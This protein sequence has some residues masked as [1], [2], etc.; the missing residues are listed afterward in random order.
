MA[1]EK[2][3]LV[4]SEFLDNWYV[5]E[6]AEHEGIERADQ[7]GPNSYT[8]FCSSRIS[9]ADVEGH[10]DQMV[11]LADAIESSGSV[12]FKR[13]AVRIENDRAFFWSPR[14]S[15]REGE[16]SLACALELAKQI[17]EVAAVRRG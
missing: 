11:A 8:L 15:R 17:R 5:I 9:D 6:R 10:L 12:S 4:K 7:V 14:N 2:L 16:T 1:D 13:C 3:I